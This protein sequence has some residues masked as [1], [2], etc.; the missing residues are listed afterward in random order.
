MRVRLLGP[1]DVV[2]DGV[3]KPMQGLRRTAILA[4]LALHPGDV[5]STERLVEIVWGDTPPAAAESNLQ[6]HL[7]H[8]RNALGNRAADHLHAV[9]FTA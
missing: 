4:A 5:V 1:V 6:S 7:S 3:P 2:I 9:G 8:L